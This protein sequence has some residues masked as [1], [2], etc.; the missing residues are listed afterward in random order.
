MANF[1]SIFA[2]FSRSIFDNTDNLSLMT[3]CQIFRD[4][5]SDVLPRGV[6]K[7]LTIRRSSGSSLRLISPSSNSLSVMA[8]AAGEE[9]PRSSETSFMVGLTRSR[10]IIIVFMPGNEYSVIVV[11]TCWCRERVKD[12][13]RDAVLSALSF[14]LY[15]NMINVINS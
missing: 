1:L 8:V 2:K 12:I 13:K 9:T 10:M 3:L 14:V 15:V 5:S 4:F 11:L 7:T 6:R